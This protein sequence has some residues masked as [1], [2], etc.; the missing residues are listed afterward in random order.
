MRSTRRDD[1]QEPHSRRLLREVK[2]SCGQPDMKQAALSNGT[3]PSG[4]A[5]PYSQPSDNQF[6]TLRV[7][8]G[9][10]QIPLDSPSERDGKRKQQA[11]VNDTPHKGKQCCFHH[12]GK[13]VS[14]NV[15]LN[16]GRNP[17][18]KI[19]PLLSFRRDKDSSGFQI[20]FDEEASANK[21][22]PARHDFP[23]RDGSKAPS[24]V[25]GLA[26]Y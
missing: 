26:A 19:H 17:A 11:V 1:Y 21:A 7:Q 20:S 15:L 14:R 13:R 25:R 24:S 6:F 10:F 12:N 2:K 4:Q 22:R 5:P 8:I 16:F 18:D 3:S 23:V 9:F